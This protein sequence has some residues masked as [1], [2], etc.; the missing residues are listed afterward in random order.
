[1]LSIDHL[2]A[3][4]QVLQSHSAWTIKCVKG[5]TWRIYHWDIISCTTFVVHSFFHLIW[6][7]TAIKVLEHVPSGFLKGKNQFTIRFVGTI[8]FFSNA[9]FEP[10]LHLQRRSSSSKSPRSEHPGFIRH[11]YILPS[12]Y[13][14]NGSPMWFYQYTLFHLL[15]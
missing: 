9:F 5:F 2:W 13:V 1:M 11:I 15:T 12:K 8:F 3:V 10:S 6:C 14:A 4:N 7:Q